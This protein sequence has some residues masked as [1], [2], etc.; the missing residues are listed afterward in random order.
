MLLQLIYVLQ[1][2]TMGDDN[3][4]LFLK[5]KWNWIK[6][7]FWNYPTLF[8]TKL[9]STYL[10]DI[11]E[12]MSHGHICDVP[13]VAKARTISRNRLAPTRTGIERSSQPETVE[14]LEKCQLID[15]NRCL[16]SNLLQCQHLSHVL[17]SVMLHTHL[18]ANTAPRIFS[19]SPTVSQEFVLKRCEH[20]LADRHTCTLHAHTHTHMP[21]DGTHTCRLTCV[22][23]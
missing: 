16:L 20:T 9:H 23:T 5:L 14:K 15:D 8:K 12:K 18:R 17:L 21:S 4:V 22:W 2:F 7:A 6:G 19:I 1:I 13:A 10:M 11:Q 3:C